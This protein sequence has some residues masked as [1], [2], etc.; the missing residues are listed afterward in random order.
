ML[1][2]V[3][4]NLVALHFAI[5]ASY[6]GIWI[7]DRLAGGDVELPAMPRA[8]HHGPFQ[9]ALTKRT[10]TMQTGVVDGVEPTAY[11]G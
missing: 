11:V 1:S 7:H 4:V 6:A 9:L 5:K 8:G 10:A 2:Q 3:D